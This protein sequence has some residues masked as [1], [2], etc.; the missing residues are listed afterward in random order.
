VGNLG[1]IHRKIEKLRFYPFLFRHSVEVGLKD[2]KELSNW[3]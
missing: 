1:F 2:K 3:F